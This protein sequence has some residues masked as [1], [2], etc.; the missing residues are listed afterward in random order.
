MF[1]VF[2]PTTLP[3]AMPGELLSAA[4]TLVTNSGVEVP[5]PTNV[6]PINKGETPK[7][8]AEATAPRTS[9][10]PPTRSNTKPPMISNHIVMKRTLGKIR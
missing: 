6:K 1:A 4:V 3:T 8:L 5:N 7:D 9:N 10:S 2:D